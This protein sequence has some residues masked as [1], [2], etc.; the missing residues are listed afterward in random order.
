MLTL[1]AIYLL[2]TIVS[3][4]G[5]DG[6]S[7]TAYEEEQVAYGTSDEDYAPDYSAPT[8]GSNWEM[9]G[10]PVLQSDG[11][12]L[13]SVNTPVETQGAMEDV[14]RDVRG[15]YP[16]Y[17]RLSVD[18][19]YN[20]GESGSPSVLVGKAGVAFDPTSSNDY[21]EVVNY[22]PKLQ[23]NCDGAHYAGLE[24]A[25]TPAEWGCWQWYEYQ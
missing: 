13:L 3:N 15:Q 11:S 10:D 5:A 24:M 4:V 18:M 9:M 7:G 6:E 23:Q 1:A 25:D 12:L 22:V 17:E 14:M 20:S 21:Y 19:F 8:N 16:Q 2:F